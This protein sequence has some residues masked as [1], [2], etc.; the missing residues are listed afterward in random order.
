MG[1]QRGYYRFP[2]IHGDDIVFVAKD[3]LWLVQATGGSR[4]A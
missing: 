2:T 4:A 1:E 3:D